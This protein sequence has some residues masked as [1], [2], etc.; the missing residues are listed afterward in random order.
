MKLVEEYP[1]YKYFIF[2]FILITILFIIVRI[3][4]IYNSLPYLIEISRDVD[5]DILIR[6]LNNG[7][8]DFYKPIEMPPGIPDWPPYYLYFWYFM[9]FPMGLIPVEVGVYVWD[10]FRLVTSSIV[11]YNSFNYFKNKKDIFIFY[12]LLTAGFCIDGWFNNINFIILFLLYYSYTALD[13]GDK[14]ISGLLFTLST[15]KINSILFIPILLLVKKIRFKDL[16]HYLL[17]F[18]LICL[19]YMIFPNYFLQMISNWFSSQDT[20]QGMTFLDSIL[21]KGLQPS[22]LM[23]LSFLYIIFFENIGKFRKK[24]LLRMILLSLL[25]FYYL[26]LS[27]VTWII[28]MLIT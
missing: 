14:W 15:F 2:F 9:F 27:L 6:G 17:P 25:F 5:F 1:F 11:V 23:F 13:K 10:I 8:I 7:L 26:Y 22:H 18:L 4:I 24:S 19:P 21:W 3:L 28:T 20:L 12:L 16:Y